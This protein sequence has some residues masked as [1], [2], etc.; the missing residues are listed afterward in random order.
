MKI[1]IIT[2]IHGNSPA[3]KAVLNDI[4]ERKLDHIYC[5]GDIVG[6][7]P[8][9]NEVL[10]LL[11]SRK[12]I[13]YVIGNHDMAVVAAFYGQEPPVGHQNERHHHE[14]L[15]ARINSSY[16]QFIEKMS[17]QIDQTHLNKR[18][19]F[20]HYHLNQDEQF[21]GIDR[22]PSA[23]RL[24]KLYE[25]TKYDLVSFGHHHIIHKIKSDTRLYFNPGA[26][27]CYEKPLARYGIVEI[28]NEGIKVEPVEIPYDN[29]DFLKSYIDL[30]VPEREFILKIFHGNQM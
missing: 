5:L 13:S 26:L 6:I 16:I 27:G 9:S 20:V 12:D 17:K 19:L 22:F 7:G 18:L 25:G 1:A 10:E 8:D 30:K 23:E 11:T 29:R 21:F 2:D 24:D 3:L 28:T 14:W 4:D 15:A